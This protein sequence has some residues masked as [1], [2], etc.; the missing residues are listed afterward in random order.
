VTITGRSAAQDRKQRRD[1]TV[2]AQSWMTF[3]FWHRRHAVGSAA[4]AIHTLGPVDSRVHMDS[5]QS[6]PDERDSRNTQ[7]L[8]IEGQDASIREH[9]VFPAR[10]KSVDAI[11]EVAIQTSN[12]AAEYGQVGGGV[13][14][15][16]DRSGTNRFHGSGT[17][18]S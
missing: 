2:A 16:L 3:R 12:Y 5:E 13:F 8:R 6:C 15:S 11:Q 1:H 9:P 14:Q 7:S 4:F 17:T 18:I 10:A